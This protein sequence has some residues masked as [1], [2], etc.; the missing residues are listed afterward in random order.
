VERERAVCWTL[1]GKMEFMVL[2]HGD[3]YML[4]GIRGKNA[5]RFLLGPP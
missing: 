5:F 4:F 3:Q 1:L 2:V